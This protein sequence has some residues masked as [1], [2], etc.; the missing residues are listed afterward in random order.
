MTTTS[1]IVCLILVFICGFMLGKRYILK[2]LSLRA[3]QL[4]SDGDIS[5]SEFYK[6]VVE[7]ELHE[8]N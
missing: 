5:K 7:S 3:K 4:N 6:K 8:D 1:I 2:G